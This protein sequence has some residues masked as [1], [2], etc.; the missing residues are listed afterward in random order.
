MKD[1]SLEEQIRHK[2]LEELEIVLANAS[3][4]DIEN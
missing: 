3:G 4:N 1:K 2:K